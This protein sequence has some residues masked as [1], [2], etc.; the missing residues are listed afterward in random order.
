MNHIIRSAI[1]LTISLSAASTAAAQTSTGELYTLTNEAA[2]NRVA[3][4]D[5]AADGA[6]T[7]DRYVATG[8][9]GSG[10]GLG[11][12]GA[13]VLTDDERFLLAVNAGS[14]E[15]S[16][17]RVDE[18]GVTPIDL[19][20]A[21]GLQPV[22]VTQFGDLV[23]VVSAETSS[24]AG[25]RLG[26]DGDLEYIAGSAARLGPAT[27]GPAQVQFGPR[28]R[29]VYVTEKATNR[30]TRFGLNDAGIPVTRTSF[31]SPGQTPFGFALGLRGQLIVSEAAG[32]APGAST[33]TS[34]VQG[35]DGELTAVTTSLG[36]GQAA[37]CW[38]A[39]SAD[40]RVAY[41]SNTA[42]DTITSYAVAFDGTLT[43]LESIA[44]S[45][46]DGPTDMAVT[47]D[48]R[49][50]YVLNAAEG[51]IGDY[52]IDVGGT[53]TGIPGVVDGLPTGGLTG[54]AVR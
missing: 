51:A 42:D 45:V 5:R 21:R 54:L 7:F 6:L 3:V 18:D 35:A 10:G 39:L 4:F 16:V 24:I 38:I 32:G 47:R 13:V 26:F 53:L 52:T 19:E 31:D 17:L 30:I 1:A 2:G 22:S 23:F 46:G 9:L 37:A 12:Q 40:G 33:A 27:T 49:F 11:N 43:V 15:I 25:F 36:A 20:G 14:H 28:G 50:F 29:H 48:G 34:Y 41:A 44:A 8:G